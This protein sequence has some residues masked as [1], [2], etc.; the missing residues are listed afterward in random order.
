MAE[1][2]PYALRA[3]ATL[4]GLRIVP[5]MLN[6]RRFKVPLDDFPRR[7]AITE[8]CLKLPAFADARPEAQPDAE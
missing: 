6:A 5:Q 2:G 8:A 4:A 7:L 1:P 3:K